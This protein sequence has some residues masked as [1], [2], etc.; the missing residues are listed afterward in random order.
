MNNKRLFSLILC[1]LLVIASVFA[2]SACGGG[3]DE[4]EPDDN[5]PKIE[6][7]TFKDKSVEYDGTAKTI[8]VVG[9]PEGATVTYELDNSFT[10][11]GTYTVKATVSLKGYQDLVLTAKLTITAPVVVNTVK[12]SFD[13]NGGTEVAAI[14]VEKG[15]PATAPASPYKK[16]YEFNGWYLENYKYDFTKN[17]ESELTLTAKWKLSTYEIIYDV[18]YGENSPLNPPTYNIE[19]EDIVLAPATPI[20]GSEFDYW[21]ILVDGQEQ[22]ITTITKGSD[23]NKRVY[24]KYRYQDFDITYVL[25]DATNNPAN[26]A[27]SNAGVAELVL[28]D[29]TRRGYDFVAWFTDSGFDVDSRIEVIEHLS[30]PITVYAK[31]TPTVY[32]ITYDNA[33]ASELPSNVATTYTI[34]DTVTFPTLSDRTDYL[35]SG[36]TVG[37]TA[38]TGIALNSVDNVTAVAVWTPKTYNIVYNLAGGANNPDNPATFN[39]ETATITLKAPTKDY[40]D[41]AGWTDASGDPI[42]EIALGTSG[43]VTVNAN[44]TPTKYSIT[45]NLGGGVNDTLN[46]AEYTVEDAFTLEVATKTGFK[47]LGWYT[48]NNTTSTKVTEIVLGTNGPITLYAQ[49]KEYE[50]GISYNAMG[51]TLP[52][53]NPTG[54]DPEVGV[55]SFLPATRAGYTFAGWYTSASFLDGE[56]VTSIEVGTEGNLTLYAKFVEG[57]EGL[58]FLEQEGAFYVIEYTGTE[59]VVYIPATYNGKD[60][61]GLAGDAFKNNTL[62]TEVV[63]PDSITAIGANAFYGC[64]ALE[65]VVVPASVTSIYANAFYGCTSLDAILCKATSKPTGFAD[66]FDNLDGTSKIEVIYGYTD[67][68]DSTLPDMPF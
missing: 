9:A 63:L 20:E 49:W 32:T 68:G 17:V 7:V 30:A 46:P 45:Y 66:G 23:G 38:S 55:A 11:R 2:L 43:N 19:S 15:T 42:T 22:P 35:F 62:I 33:E 12:V 36:W 1:L 67:D 6:G 39:V 65:R 25:G 51:G 59:S 56:L 64:T 53:G 14:D 26:P 28:A 50:A 8:E 13:S 44:W 61:V 57:T 60:V 31:F 5:L 27:T 4:D 41:F 54:Y 10:A 40:Y 34:N 29:P 52:K 24:A 18:G 21:Y 48:E 37:G 58:E 47:F 3:G 16:G